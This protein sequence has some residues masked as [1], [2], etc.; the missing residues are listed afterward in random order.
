MCRYLVGV[1]SHRAFYPNDNPHP[2]TVYLGV[3]VVIWMNTEAFSDVRL[4]FI[5]KN[6][7][8]VEFHS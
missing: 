8:H 4:I 3:C 7:V 2:I 5:F 6:G 1:S